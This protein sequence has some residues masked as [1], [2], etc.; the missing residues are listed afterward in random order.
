MW[1]TDHIKEALDRLNKECQNQWSEYEG[2]SRFRMHQV[3]GASQVCPEEGLFG[4]TDSLS[5]GIKQTYLFSSCQY[6][7]RV[8]GKE[9]EDN[10][11]HI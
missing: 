7:P 9:V 6:H 11:G 3:L 8:G 1:S 10:C 4:I 2:S 5:N